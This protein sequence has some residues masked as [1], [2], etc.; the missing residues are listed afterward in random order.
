LTGHINF[1]AG[2]GFW[3]FKPGSLARGIV[4]R[5]RVKIKNFICGN[6]YSDFEDLLLFKGIDI[7]K[8]RKIIFLFR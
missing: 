1:G 4:V 6:Y 3:H 7:K 8:E 5:R 2:L